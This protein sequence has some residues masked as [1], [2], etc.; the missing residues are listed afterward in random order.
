M[1]YTARFTKNKDAAGGHHL[2]SSFGTPTAAFSN[3][4]WSRSLLK[5]YI[6][7]EFSLIYTKL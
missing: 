4:I 3:I 2:I 6:K 1:G 5:R 7:H